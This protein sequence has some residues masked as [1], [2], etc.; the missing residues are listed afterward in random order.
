MFSFSLYRVLKC[1]FSL[2]NN[3]FITRWMSIY[4]NLIFSYWYKFFL[5][6]S[7]TIKY[8]YYLLRYLYIILVFYFSRRNTIWAFYFSLTVWFFRSLYL[9][10]WILCNI[11][12][13]FIKKFNTSKI[14]TSLV[15]FFWLHWLPKSKFHTKIQL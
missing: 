13:I 15:P 5:I 6:Y 4:W 1:L 8:I 2:Y 9:F 14:L 7:N 10:I 12:P 11:G 3:D